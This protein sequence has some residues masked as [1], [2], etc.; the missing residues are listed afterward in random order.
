MKLLARVRLHMGLSFRSPS[1]SHCKIGLTT[2][3]LDRDCVTD[4]SLL[5]GYGGS[6]RL[7]LADTR[8]SSTSP[9]KHIRQSTIFSRISTHTLTHSHTHTHRVSL[10][11]TTSFVLSYTII[12]SSVN[13]KSQFVSVSHRQPPSVCPRKL[14]V[15]C[16]SVNSHSNTE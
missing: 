2:C 4:Y 14:T 12:L 15:A 13:D 10:S 6:A 9:K 7:N 8:P 3:A 5:D 11:Q 16:P 1:L